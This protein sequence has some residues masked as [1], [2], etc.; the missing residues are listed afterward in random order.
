[1]AILTIRPTANGDNI[2][3]TPDAGANWEMVDEAVAD[4]GG[5]FNEGD[6]YDLYELE[7]HGA[8]AD[9]IDQIEVF[10]RTRISGGVN[11]DHYP[12]IKTNGA[13]HNGDNES[14]GAWETHSK[15]WLQNPETVA[16]WTWAD[17]DNLQA[18][19]YVVGTGAN[20]GEIT[21]CYVEVTHNPAAG[22][23]SGGDVSGIPEANLG[24]IIGVD[25]ANIGKLCGV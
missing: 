6:G 18:G 17:I 11:Q 7:N 12:K 25:I 15:I 3:L 4:E 16:A 2:D 8:E 1:M 9:P 22:G 24:K 19:A 21:Q 23:W 10:V 14:V 20:D 5:T 13:E